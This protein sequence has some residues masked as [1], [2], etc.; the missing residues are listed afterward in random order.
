MYIQITEPD[1]VS[2]VP[3]HSYA[4]GIDLGTTHSV[5]AIVEDGHVK[6]LSFDENKTLV[7]SV[8]YYGGDRPIV[9]EEA[10][11]LLRQDP[12]MGIRSV[13]R[14]M[15]A[16]PHLSEEHGRLIVSREGLPQLKFGPHFKTPIEVSAD[17]LHALRLKA[18]DFFGHTVHQAVIT[19]PAYFDEA[20]RQA[21]KDAARL[22]GLQVLRLVN[23]PTAAALAY[24]LDTGIEGTYVILDLGG[25]TFDISLLRLQQGVFQ[26]LATGGDTHLGGDDVDLIIAYHLFPGESLYPEHLTQARWVK[27]YL[28]HHDVWEEGDQ[29]LTRDR[30]TQLCQALFARIEQLCRQVL[31]DANLDVTALK[32]VVLVGGAT[33]MPAFQELVMD[34]FGQKPLTD[35]NPDEV[36]AV[37]AALQADALTQGSTQLLLDVTPLSLG[38]ETMGGLVDKIIYRNSPIP[39]MKTQTFTTYEDGQREMKIHVL[40]GES[41]EIEHCRSLGEFVLSDI[42]PLPAGQARIDVTFQLDAD[43]LLTVEAR[44]QTTQHQQSIQIKPAYGLTPSQLE[45]M[46]MDNY[47]IA[48]QDRDLRQLEQLRQE[49]QRTIRLMTHALDED[50]HL[51]NS[52]EF[53]SLNH[54]LENLRHAVQNGAKEIVE[55]AIH[56]LLEASQEFAK[57]RL[58]NQTRT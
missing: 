34:I 31:K 55:S 2:L 3:E 24:G 4:L 26:V 38:V 25:G 49:G 27:H 37:G 17:I 15:S 58:E 57:K 39:I 41:D 19:V 46:L 22:A 8:V 40:Q 16:S 53:A 42:P 23:E 44:E 51:L 13:K 56:E 50:K 18:E 6:V 9:G 30:L 36:V 5:V 10:L 32:G 28:T 45:L 29:H 47:R 1:E 21:T 12:P 54:L 52:E 43:G 48:Y 33:R 7:P 11:E 14:L 20:A 35:L